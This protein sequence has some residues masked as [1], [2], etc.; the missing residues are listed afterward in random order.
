[1][2]FL[3]SMVGIRDRYYQARREVNIYRR[4]L[5]WKKRGCIFIHVPKVAGTSISSEIY[6]RTLGHYR[7]TEIKRHFPRLY[8]DCLTFSFVRDPWDR[9]YSAYKFAVLGKNGS[10]G[11]ADPSNYRI[12][13]FRNFES[14]VLE[15][16]AQRELIDED[17]VFQPQYH[18]VCNDSYEIIVDEIGKFETLADDLAR[19]GA[20]LGLSFELEYMNRTMGLSDYRSKYSTSEMVDVVASKYRRDIAFFNYSF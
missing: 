13:E 7:A 20:L 1:M 6:G 16:L 5:Y 4:F 11:I 17:P 15:W 9:V 19:I 18:Y 10:M 3:N 8:E 14:F 12:P 2:G